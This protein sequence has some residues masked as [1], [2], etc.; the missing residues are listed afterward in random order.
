MSRG[1]R[2]DARPDADHPVATAGDDDLARL[3][4]TFVPEPDLADMATGSGIGEE[5][6]TS[7][8]VAGWT[9][10][11]RV[12]GLLRVIVAGAILGSTFFANIFQATNTLPN[13]AY[14]LMAGSVLSALA[15]PIIVA[16]L[17]E[18]GI[19]RARELLHRL[20]GVV[21]A[22]FAVIALAVIAL[23][24]I[25]VHLLTL[26]VPHADKGA[27][28]KEC[29]VL[30]FLVLPE[31]ACYGII[32]LAVA[33]QNARGKFRLAAAAPAMENIG[34]ITTLILVRQIFGPDTSHAST[35][36]LVFLGIGASLA[37][38]LHAAIQLYGA[39]RVGLPLWPGWGWKDPVVRALARR[40]VPAV[41]TAT[42]DASWLFA[43]I[44]AA[45][46]V[47]GGVVALQVGINFYYLPVALSAKAVGTVLLRE[48]YDR[49]ISWAWFVAV[50]AAL[51]LLV[52]SKPIADA[53]AFGSMRENH[54]VALLS[55]SIASLGIALVGATMY[56]FSK[57][58]CYARHD[59]IPPL[60]GCVLMVGVVVIGS[61]LSATLRGAAVL[62]GLG[63]TVT[64]GEM[65]RAFITDRAARKGTRRQGASRITTLIRHCG[66]AVATIIP[67]SILGR[68]VQDAIGGHIGAVVGVAIGAGGGL[69]AYVAVQ[70]LLGAQELPPRLQIGE[71]RRRA[72]A[73][74]QAA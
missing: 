32:A 52:S 65:G 38:V 69:V 29:W 51:T 35:G 16:A 71:R 73:E 54:G 43:L 26:G 37:V 21:L 45:G 2:R 3:D 31:I 5:T 74:A 20:V 66:V 34:T 13:V 15:V 63:I 30:L 53:I 18:H 50:P 36:Y 9:L 6:S 8:G 14:N 57:Q 39:W 33:A 70:S 48:T 1:D 11:S 47:P 44:V 62:V 4:R 10:I 60:V 68:A 42:L 28:H 23:S 27:A 56:E 17:D 40:F 49:G 25:I 72:V 58:A 12:T 7:Y 41:G 55:A 24:P 59:V 61:P 64:I 46:V 67:A 19:E 22:G